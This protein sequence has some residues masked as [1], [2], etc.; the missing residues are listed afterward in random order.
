MSSVATIAAPANLTGVSKARIEKDSHGY[1]TLDASGHV[2]PKAKAVAYQPGTN[3]PSPSQADV[4]AGLK[5][6]KGKPEIIPGESSV[7]VI[8]AL[9]SAAQSVGEEIGH[10]VNDAERKVGEEAIKGAIDVVKP[11]ATKVSLYG[12][13][14]FGAVAMM[15]FGLS[16]LLKPVGGPDLAGK[17]KAGAKAAVLK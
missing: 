1:Y 15:I 9:G 2:V 17:V 3:A 14:I 11:I 5:P 8:G 16:E 13:L 4:N 7:P 12:V 10:A 6:P